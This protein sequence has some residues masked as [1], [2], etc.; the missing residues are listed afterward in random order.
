M[1]KLENYFWLFFKKVK[2][3]NSGFRSIL[4]FPNMLH[5][6]GVIYRAIVF[7]STGIEKTLAMNRDFKKKIEQP[8]AIVM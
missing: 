3:K 4:Y 1:K 7:R 6:G 8:I 2:D 5:Q